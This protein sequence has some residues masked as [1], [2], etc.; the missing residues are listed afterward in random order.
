M[1]DHVLMGEDQK[2]PVKCWTPSIDEVTEKQL[3]TIAQLPFIVKHVSAMPDAHKGF[4]ST[5][6]TVVATRRAI[7]PGSV[8][9]DMGC[10]ML[11]MMT[12]IHIDIIMKHRFDIFD[13]IEKFVPVGANQHK[14]KNE[15]WVGFSYTPHAKVGDKFENAKYQLGTLGGGNHFIE[16][17]TD[18]DNRISIMLHSGSRGIGNLIAQEHIKTA[19]R[20]CKE[21][22]INLP[23]KELAY[24]VDS[25]PEFERYMHDLHWAQDYAMENRRV[26]FEYVVKAIQSVIGE[27]QLVGDPVNCH[28]NYTA[29]EH[30]FGEDVWVT[31]KGAIRARTGDMGIIPGSMGDK[32]YIVRGKGCADAFCSAPH[33][34]GR[35]LSRTKAEEIYTVEDLAKQTE[36]IVCKK[37]ASV[38]DEI[39]RAYKPIEDVIRYSDDLVEVV[40]EIRQ[41]ICVKG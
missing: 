17:C 1:I 39:P 41:L 35:V 33:G 11:W 10:G 6:G 40:H 31:R 18:K 7:I 16:V 12:D 38:L 34:A 29:R 19:E 22:H 3:R 8:G 5:V 28:H 14:V 21:W 32:S 25:H 26:M 24:L 13:A 2:V 4:G 20:L 27:F 30:H 9:V 23:D 15:E 37:D 36:G